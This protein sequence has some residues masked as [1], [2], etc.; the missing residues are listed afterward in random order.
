MAEVKFDRLNKDVV[1]PV[2]EGYVSKFTTT[3]WRYIKV[4]SEDEKAKKAAL[5]K[6]KKDAEKAELK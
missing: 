3:G 2:K 1:P 4:V 5:A 6:Q